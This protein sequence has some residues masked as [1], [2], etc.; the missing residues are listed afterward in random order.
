MKKLLILICTLP[1][2]WCCGNSQKAMK[3]NDQ[4]IKDVTVSNDFS[5]FTRNS[6][7]TEIIEASILDSTLTLNIKYNGG[8]K[9]HTFELIGSQ[10]IQKSMPPIRGIMLAHYSNNDD[11]RE[12]I[13]EEL[14]F[15]VAK[16]KYPN[17]DIYLNLQGYK[18]R[19]LFQSID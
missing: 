8:C 9:D 2:I 3:K 19:V 12:V 17:G 16:F 10:M 5:E 13:E 14:K 7:E 1:I 4:I 15:N 11:C 6:S 18:E